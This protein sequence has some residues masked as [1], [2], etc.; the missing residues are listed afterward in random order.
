MFL[1]APWRRFRFGP[2]RSGSVP[3]RSAPSQGLGFSPLV[4]LRVAV[5]PVAGAV[6]SFPTFT[7]AYHG[8]IAAKAAAWVPW[9]VLSA[10]VCRFPVSR[11]KPR[12]P[13]SVG[14]PQNRV[15]ASGQVGCGY[16]WNL[17]L[18]PRFGGVSR[19]RWGESLFDNQQGFKPPPFPPLWPA[20]SQ[21]LLDQVR[22]VTPFS[23]L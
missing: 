21:N 11:C 19:P 10:A 17:H 9:P 22:G 7:A 5:A 1:P 15:L 6:R 3:L 2:L 4:A 18:L 12:F 8:R 13:S 16:P 20:E 14:H 23:P